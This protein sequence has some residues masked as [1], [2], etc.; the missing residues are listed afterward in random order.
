ML[1]KQE[2]SNALPTSSISNNPYPLNGKLKLGETESEAPGV[3]EIDEYDYLTNTYIM[4]RPTEDSIPNSKLCFA[5][6]KLNP[7]VTGPSGTTPA[8][9]S[10][11][12]ADGNPNSG[13]WVSFSEENGVPVIGDPVGTK[14]DSYEMVKDNTGFVC[15]AYDSDEDKVFCRPDFSVVGRTNWAA[16]DL[17]ITTPFTPEY[18]DWTSI[19]EYT[20]SDDEKE[21][22]TMGVND[23]VSIETYQQSQP[24]FTLTWASNPALSGDNT[25]CT[26]RVELLGEEDIHLGYVYCDTARADIDTGIDR[27]YTVVLGGIEAPTGSRPIIGITGS[28]KGQI[29]KLDFQYFIDSTDVRIVQILSTRIKIIPNYDN[30]TVIR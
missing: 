23:G 1:G 22:L 7:T 21:G 29:T 24:F 20:L 25:G 11:G 5:A 26:L 28:L 6:G 2:G 14:E 15:I 16:T 12:F 19:H 30:Y 9:V 8:L 4:K 18:K 13:R 3:F 10:I 17:L 27:T